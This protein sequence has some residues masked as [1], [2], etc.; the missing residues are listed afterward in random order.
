MLLFYFHQRTTSHFFE[1]IENHES[2]DEKNL[3]NES[4]V[5]ENL[6]IETKSQ[7][8]KIKN[9][10]N[11]KNPKEMKILHETK[12]FDNVGETTKMPINY[13]AKPEKFVQNVSDCVTD[14]NCYIYY[15]HVG[16]TGGTSIENQFWRLFPGT[17]QKSCCFQTM[18]E[19]FRKNP[20]KYCFKK[21]SSYQLMGYGLAEVIEK[22]MELHYKKT[23]NKN[24]KA[25]VISTFR[26]P[27]AKTLSSIHQVCN[28]NLGQRGDPRK[29]ACKN[30]DYDK[31]PEVWNQFLK[32]STRVYKS[33]Y[34]DI[35]HMDRDGVEVL[36]IDLVDITNFFEQLK[37]KLLDPFSKKIIPDK[38]SNKESLEYCNF[39]LNSAMIKGL[40][41]AEEIYRRL[42]LGA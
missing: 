22:C 38:R 36:T 25:I 9:I 24:T 30:C 17:K 6:G 19:R 12:L 14:K 23:G 20:E 1:D 32:E 29:N 4:D 8:S 15:H 37:K 41:L 7:V 18:L 34:R 28:K 31:D 40:G 21:F 33:L 13:F 5:L 27:I 3:L 42:S 2:S 35:S 10:V 26:E 39:K 16:K 11:Y